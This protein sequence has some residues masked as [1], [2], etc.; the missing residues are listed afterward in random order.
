MNVG[1][2]LVDYLKQKGFSGLHDDMGC[3]CFLDDMF[4]CDNNCSGCEPCYKVKA[5]CDDCESKDNCEGVG[6]TE[7]CWT[8]V[9]ADLQK[10]GNGAAPGESHH[11]GAPAKA[12]EPAPEPITSG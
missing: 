7:F 1:E 3:A 10:Y 2:I 11:K 12:A 5:H 8:T 9:E 6:E 4:P